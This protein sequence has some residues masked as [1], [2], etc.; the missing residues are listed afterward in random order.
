M[1]VRAI[2]EDD[3]HIARIESSRGETVLEG[4]VMQA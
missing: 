4:P 3:L 1:S 2:A